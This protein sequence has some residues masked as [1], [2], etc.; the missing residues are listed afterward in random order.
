MTGAILFEVLQACAADAADRRMHCR[1]GSAGCG[2]PTVPAA[3]SAGVS[4]PHAGAG[5][6]AA[7]RGHFDLTRADIQPVRRSQAVAKKLAPLDVYR[8]AGRPSRSRRSSSDVAARSENVS[9]WW[10]YR[11]RFVTEKRIADGAQFMREH[12]ALLDRS[13]DGIRVPPEFIVAIVGVETNYGRITGKYRVIDALSTLAFHYPPRA[14]FFRGELE[15]V[16]PAGDEEG[17]RSDDAQ[18]SYAGAM[19]AEPVHADQ[20]RAWAKAEDGD[21][22]RPLELA[23]G[24]H[25]ERRQLFQR[26]RLGDR[27]ARDRGTRATGRAVRRRPD[28]QQPTD[29]VQQM[30]AWGYAPLSHVDAEL[31]S[32]LLMLDGDQRTGVLA[33]VQE[34]LC[35]HALQQEPAVLDGGLRARAPDRRWRVV[36]TR[37]AHDEMRTVAQI[38]CSRCALMRHRCGGH[39]SRAANRARAGGRRAAV[40]RCA[41]ETSR[42]TGRALSARS[43]TTAPP[44]QPSMC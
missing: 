29:P 10:E 34:L 36:A 38:R 13:R 40:L 37:S 19:G 3:A 18:G 24:H 14:A 33:D 20:H 42:A 27:P 44:R 21:G 23:A 25:R 17:R 16:L 2:G 1:A 12:R 11:A 22:R 7:E 35:D 4:A 31:A 26:A 39:V 32:T 6:G 9:P 8:A 30:E 5:A 41:S 43:T 15:A 28:N